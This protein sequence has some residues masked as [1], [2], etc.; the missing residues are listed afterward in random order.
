[1]DYNGN[2]YTTVWYIPAKFR[3][4]VKQ[5][6]PTPT[7]TRQLFEEYVLYRYGNRKRSYGVCYIP[8]QFR[9]YDFDEYNRR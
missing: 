9:G 1:M 3:S 5:I 2:N 7:P 8:P 4:I 6:L